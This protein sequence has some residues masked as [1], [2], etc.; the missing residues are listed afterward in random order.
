MYF[1]KITL[2]E[3]VNYQG[4]INFM[5]I[6]LSTF[7]SMITSILSFGTDIMRLQSHSG[8]TH[9]ACAV[10]SEVPAKTDAAERR[11]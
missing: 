3:I 6:I 2:I 10:I 5:S 11:Y 7:V 4:T 9:G 8:Q 1:E